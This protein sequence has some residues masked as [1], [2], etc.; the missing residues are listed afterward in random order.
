MAFESGGENGAAKERPGPAPGV[1][2]RGL[3]RR[4]ERA[5]LATS[6]Q[7]DGSGDP[8]ASLVIVAVDQDASPLLLLSDLA[9]HTA[10]LKASPRAGLLIDGTAG[11]Q[12]PLTG[13]RLSLQGSL[14]RVE[15]AAALQRFQNRHPGA[16]LYAGF[17]DFNLYRFTV[18]KAHLVAGFGAI[19]WI[20]AE[21][22]LYDCSAAEVLAAAE[23]DIVAHMN[24]DHADALALIAR[25]LLHQDDGGQGEDPWVMTGI[26]PEGFD[27][28]GP[29]GLQRVDFAG[30]FTGPIADAQAARAALVALTQQARKLAEAGR[31]SPD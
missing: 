14:G 20:D 1:Q 12:D 22:L 30:H 15:S 9:D 27:L 13:P 24:E 29:G 5:S 18:D 16:A 26:D 28:R 11:H 23:S 2:G 7:R 21:S 8:Y 10:N 6:L 31:S 4:A 17:G 25:H 19:H 3:L